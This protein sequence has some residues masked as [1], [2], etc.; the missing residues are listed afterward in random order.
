M[1][2]SESIAELGSALAS[3]QA[4][5]SNPARTQATHFLNQ[6]MLTWQK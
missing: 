1:K 2:K 3:A 5:M 6:S 4:E